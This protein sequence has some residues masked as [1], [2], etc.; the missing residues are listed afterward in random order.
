MFH[1]TWEKVLLVKI[2]DVFYQ[3]PDLQMVKTPK[4]ADLVICCGGGGDLEGNT[5]V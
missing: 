5:C 1:T 2:T 4:L 3:F